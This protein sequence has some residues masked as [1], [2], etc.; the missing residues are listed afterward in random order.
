[1]HF[2]KLIY[3]V[4]GLEMMLVAV[5]AVVDWHRTSR[6]SS[7]VLGRRRPLDDRRRSEAHVCDSDQCGCLR[8]LETRARVIQVML[9]AADCT[10]ACSRACLKW[11]SRFRPA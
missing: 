1:M 9:L 4:P 5:L 2:D 8:A 10:S 6:A 11:V 3:V 7:L